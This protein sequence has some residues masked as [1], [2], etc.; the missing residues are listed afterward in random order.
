MNMDFIDN[1]FSSFHNEIKIKYV[2]R[3]K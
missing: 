2:K 3:E 1:L